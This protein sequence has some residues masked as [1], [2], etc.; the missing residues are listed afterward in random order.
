MRSALCDILRPIARNTAGA[1]PTEQTAK[2]H[3]DFVTD[4]DLAVDR[5]LSAALTEVTPDVPVLSEEREITALPERYWMIDPIDGTSNLIAGL[6]FVGIAVALIHEGEPILSAVAD[7]MGGTV[8]SAELG[9]GAFRDDTRLDVAES[10][11]E[12]IGVTSGVLEL[13]C[14][15]PALFADLRKLGRIRNLGSQALQ[16]CSVANGALGANISREAKLWDDIAA[17]LIAREAGY[18]YQALPTGPNAGDDQHSICCHPALTDRM[19][20]L[21]DRLWPLA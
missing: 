4:I 16:L 6:P 21:G 12:L 13:T 15:D 20:A 9:Q 7:I 10:P 11:A 2:G 3:Q 8:Y 18:F 1:R 14:Q 19:R 5:A 17:S